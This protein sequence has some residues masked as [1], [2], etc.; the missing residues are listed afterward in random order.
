MAMPAQG[1]LNRDA[2][3]HEGERAARK[4]L[5]WK[6]NRWIPNGGDEAHGVGK[7]RF[8]G[9]QVTSA[10]CARAPC[11]FGRPGPRRNFTSTTLNGGSCSE[12]EAVE[13]VLLE[14]Q[15]EAAA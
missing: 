8:G 9:E 10:R 5:P 4:R 12:H 14:E 15:V 1:G 3:V 11:D 2:G 7:I 13:M 6:R